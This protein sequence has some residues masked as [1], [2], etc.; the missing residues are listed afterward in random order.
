VPEW[1]LWRY[2]LSYLSGAAAAEQAGF[3]VSSKSL[4]IQPSALEALVQEK[5]NTISRLDEAEFKAILENKFGKGP[6]TDTCLAQY[7][8]AFSQGAAV[9]LRQYRKEAESLLRGTSPDKARYV[10][11]FEEAETLKTAMVAEAKRLG[12]STV[13][14]NKVIERA[15]ATQATVTSE[16]R[17]AK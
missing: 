15:L 2:A 16:S 7:R 3:S 14:A 6:I 9:G 10:T 12:L 13:Q 4:G 8:R 1:H 17:S 5:L 11:D